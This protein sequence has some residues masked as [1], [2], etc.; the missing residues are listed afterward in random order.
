MLGLLT[1]EASVTAGPRLQGACASQLARVLSSP[2]AYGIFP[3]QVSNP[4][5][6]YWQADS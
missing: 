5:L 6:L 3:D 4:R 2:S 1:V